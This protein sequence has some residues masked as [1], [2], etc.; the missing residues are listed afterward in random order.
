MLDR[1]R[2]PIGFH[3]CADLRNIVPEHDDVVLLAVNVADVVPQQR[4]FGAIPS[5]N[6]KSRKQPH[7]K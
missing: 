6:A 5:P 1:S 7:A 4:F 2:Q 3:L